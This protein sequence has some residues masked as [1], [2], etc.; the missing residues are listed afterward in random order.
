MQQTARERGAAVILV[1]D[2]ADKHN[3]KCVQTS[4]SLARATVRSPF[5]SSAAVG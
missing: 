3:L 5:R 1:F 2:G 4:S